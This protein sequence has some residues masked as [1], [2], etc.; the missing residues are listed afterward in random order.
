MEG[1]VKACGMLRADVL[2]AACHVPSLSYGGRSQR[3][4]HVACRR[5]VC[6]MPC[7][8]PI[9]WRAQSKRVARCVPTCCVLHAA[10]RVPSLSYGGR[11]QS[12][13]HVACRR[14]VCRMLHA[15]C[16]AYP[17]E[18][19][20]KACSTLRADVL[21]AACRVLSMEDQLNGKIF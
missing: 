9:L 8:E 19:A 18:G 15:V 3:V 4:W 11:S 14:A 21:C 13:W 16:R 6:R 7:A 1:A 10:C 20:V 5:A 2:C 17:M 12:V